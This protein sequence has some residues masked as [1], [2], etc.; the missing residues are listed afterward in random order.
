MSIILY[1]R[2]IFIRNLVI[3]YYKR[4]K[5][6][7]YMFDKCS[8]L[9]TIYA[10][11]AWTTKKVT[12]GKEMFYNCTS[13]VGGAGTKFDATHISYAYAHIDGGASN[14]GYF[15]DKNAAPVATV[16]PYAV[17]SDN[18]TKLTF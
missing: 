14:P 12:S 2:D 13:L 3:D 17:L 7:V 6:F 1:H 18:N 5:T 4:K 16:E 10:G 8:S 9:T 15:T 11:N